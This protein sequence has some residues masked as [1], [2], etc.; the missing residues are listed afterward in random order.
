MTNLAK[1]E[2]NPS[3]I[4]YLKYR[5]KREAEGRCVNCGKHKNVSTLLCEECKS[6]KSKNNKI[7][8]TQHKEKGLCAKCENK[9]S[10]SSVLCTQCLTNSRQYNKENRK[11]KIELGICIYCTKIP[12]N[13]LRYCEYHKKLQAK[14][15]SKITNKK[16]NLPLSHVKKLFYYV[17]RR[18]RNTG[19]S[20]NI[21]L[22]QIST[23]LKQN[24]YYCEESDITKLGL[25]RIDNNLGYL[26]NNV[27]T[28]CTTCNLLRRNIPYEAWII[29]SKEMKCIREKGLLQNWKHLHSHRKQK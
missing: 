24:C 16:Q 8:R 27:N 28:C 17:N 12:I 10:D 29:M 20:S 2:R 11:R 23:L 13:G 14:Y 25:D 22:E 9:V 1:K 4:K 5:E 3:T 7:K 21:S 19:L 6:R 18:S 15:Q 26:L